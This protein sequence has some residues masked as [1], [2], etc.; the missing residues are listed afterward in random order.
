MNEVFGEENFLGLVTIVNNLK[1]RSDDKFFA[2]ANDYIICFSKNRERDV[3]N[4]WT[5]YPN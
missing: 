2:T 1:G 5:S 3:R 4:K